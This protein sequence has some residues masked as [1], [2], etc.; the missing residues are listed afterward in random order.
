VLL[1]NYA[2]KFG[3]VYA[4]WLG[5]VMT[6]FEKDPGSPKLLHLRAIH[7]YEWDWN[8]LMGVKWRHLLHLACD[9]KFINENCY[10]SMP[11]K[12]CI[13][14][15]FVKELEYEIARLTRVAVI[16]N[17]D[18]SKANYDRIH[19]F[20]ANVVGCSKGL[21]KKVCIVHGRTLKEAKFHVQTKMG[22]SKRH[23]QHG[24][25]YPLLQPIHCPHNFSTT[26]HCVAAH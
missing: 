20:I 17:D 8:L 18:D 9:Q 2:L 1:L 15:V 21:D 7:L 14:P 4:R 23:I 5:I 26:K 3:Y 22:I 19:A 24:R 25:L 10:G 12:E 13:D 11:G 16:M 6:M